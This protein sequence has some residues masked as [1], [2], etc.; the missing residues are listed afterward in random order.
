M[1]MGGC[2]KSY[3]VIW[4]NERISYDDIFPSRSVEHHDLGNIIRSEG[5][6]AAVVRLACYCI[7]D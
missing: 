7:G 3:L 4:K 6:T 5:F 2:G 1:R